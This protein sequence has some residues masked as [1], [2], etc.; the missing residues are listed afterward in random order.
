LASALRLALDALTARQLRGEAI[1]VT[2]LLSAAESLERLLPRAAVEVIDDQT[3]REK[4]ARLLD[5]YV[6]ANAAV[7]DEKVAALESEIA[8]LTARL[9]EKDSVIASLTGS[10]APQAAAPAPP[11]QTSPQPPLPTSNAPPANYLRLSM[12]EPWRV[13][14]GDRWKNNR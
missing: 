1:D 6:V 7:R 10:L 11:E 2:K 14:T 8:E 4:V 13:I 5:G 12:P 9:A 3:V